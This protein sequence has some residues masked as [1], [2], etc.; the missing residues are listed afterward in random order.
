MD[1]SNI[2]VQLVIVA[3]ITL[4]AP[5]A[6]KKAGISGLSL[7]VVAIVLGVL[8]VLGDNSSSLIAAIFGG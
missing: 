6:L 7:T 1:T 8:F 4:I 2:W 5:G 3:F